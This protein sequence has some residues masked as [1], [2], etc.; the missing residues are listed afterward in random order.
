MEVILSKNVEKLGKSGQV[1]KVKDGFANHFLIPQG[2]AFVANPKNLKLVTEQQ[3]QQETK[4]VKE[5]KQAE[6]LSQKLASTSCTVTVNAGEDDKLFGSVTNADIAEALAAE[7]IIVNKLDINL[8]PPIKKLGI[9]Q[10]EVKLHPEVTAQVK[11]WVVK[12]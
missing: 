7:G 3:K 11:V 12:K 10:V 9:Y 1:V 2:L 4:L 8:E 6:A 5:K